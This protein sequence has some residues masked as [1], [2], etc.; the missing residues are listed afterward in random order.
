ML[1]DLPTSL[2]QH[3]GKAYGDL[4]T[5]YV[6]INSLF[7]SS[8][9]PRPASND[10]ILLFVIGGITSAEVRQIRETVTKHNTTNKLVRIIIVK[11]VHV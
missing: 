5:Y 4:C 2:R 11:T 8:A 3:S 1:K 7:M 10:Y 6:S 9:R